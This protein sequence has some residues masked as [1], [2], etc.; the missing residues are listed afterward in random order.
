MRTIG[1][2]AMHINDSGG[3]RIVHVA[4]SHDEADT[5]R[6]TLIRWMRDIRLLGVDS[7]WGTIWPRAGTAPLLSGAEDSVQHTV[8]IHCTGRSP[9]GSAAADQLLCSAPTGAWAWL[10]SQL[11]GA[12]LFHLVHGATPAA[13]GPQS[14][15]ASGGRHHHVGPGGA[16]GGS[17]RPGTSRG[18]L[19]GLA[20]VDETV[21]HPGAAVRTARRAWP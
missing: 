13:T 7:E 20:R 11:H 14:A 4:A 8:L 9:A 6:A 10:G 5:A 18:R 15:T 3:A 2:P 12:V 16:S 17:A 21:A 19:G 1:A